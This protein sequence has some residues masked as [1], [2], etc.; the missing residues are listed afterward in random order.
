MS[1]EK[2]P[3]IY[4]LHILESIEFIE[5]Y[6]KGVKKLEFKNSPQLQDAV[7]RRIE[8]IGE[9]V[10]N[11]PEGFKKRFKDIKW[12]EIS[13]MRNKLIHEYFGV[14]VNIVW[15]VIKFDIPLLKKHI[16]EILEWLEK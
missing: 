15:D 4:I 8:I 16:K 7:I 1:K 11:L 13:G 14:N 10:K 5:K 6:T 12:K 9:A 3:K 2:D